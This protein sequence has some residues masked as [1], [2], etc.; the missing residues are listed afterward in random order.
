MLGHPGVAF[1]LAMGRPSFTVALELCLFSF[2]SSR[3]LNI[4]TNK[5]FYTEP[6]TEWFIS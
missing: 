3:I 1:P 2:F 5:H 6:S 4:S